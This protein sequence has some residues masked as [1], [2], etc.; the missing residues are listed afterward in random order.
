VPPVSKIFY[1]KVQLPKK[2]SAS[3]V[4]TPSATASASR[5]AKQVF[6]RRGADASRDEIAKRAK[7]GPGTLYRHFPSRD[8]LLRR[9]ISLKS[10]SCR[11][12]EELSA[13]SLHRGPASVAIVFIDYRRKKIIAPAL[14]Q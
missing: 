8:E 1:E 10:R 5:V 2:P 9:S 11:G 14:K 13:E 6:T 7:V 4:P 12:A 3:L